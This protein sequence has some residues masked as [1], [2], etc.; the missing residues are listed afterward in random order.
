[1]TDD[2]F[3]LQNYEKM[4]KTPNK[5]Q[6]KWTDF[7]SAHLFNIQYFKDIRYLFREAK[8]TLSLERTK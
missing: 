8:K 4:R 1:M 3:S 2:V 5:N 7:Q 6:K